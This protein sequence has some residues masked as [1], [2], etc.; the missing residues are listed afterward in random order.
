MGAVPTLQTGFRSL[1][2]LYEPVLLQVNLGRN[3]EA[4]RKLRF[5]YVAFR[6][7]HFQLPNE[8]WR[9]IYTLLASVNNPRPDSRGRAHRRQMTYSELKA[10]NLLR[11]GE[12]FLKFDGMELADYVV[13][14]ETDGKDAPSHCDIRYGVHHDN[15][16][17]RHRFH[18]RVVVSI[19][20]PTLLT[21]LIAQQPTTARPN[22]VDLKRT[23][24]VVALYR[25]VMSEHERLEARKAKRTTPPLDWLNSTSGVLSCLAAYP[26]NLDNLLRYFYDEFL[27]PSVSED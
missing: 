21:R 8:I 25:G 7:L 23:I 12:D 10:R 6:R 19:E 24:D 16:E 27:R 1:R 18:V 5:L 13:T 11:D 3:Y 14:F 26:W 4:F 17:S 22:F 20:K 2:T 15:L 9:L